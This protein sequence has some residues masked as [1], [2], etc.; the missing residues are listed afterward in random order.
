MHGF[1]FEVV[2]TVAER[3]I[4]IVE[5][6]KGK[7]VTPGRDPEKLLASSDHERSWDRF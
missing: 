5:S 3:S 2:E 7:T 6:K 1:I 4:E